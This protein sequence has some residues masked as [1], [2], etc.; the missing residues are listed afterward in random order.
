MHPQTHALLSWTVAEA[1]GLEHRRDRIIVLSAGLAPDLDGLTILGG[2]AL[3][4]DWHRTLLHHG[5]GALVMS[6][7]ALACARQRLRVGLLALVAVHLHFLCDMVG[8]AGPDGS[9][10]RVPY[11]VP[12]AM[13]HEH[14]GW[15]APWQWGLASWQNVAITIA[16]L[17]VCVQ[18]ARRRG[19]TLLEAVSLRADAAVVE[20]I[21][22]RLPP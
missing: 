4:N 18:L 5:L 6:L 21:R 13:P 19:R 15:A 8:S 16:A 3:Y 17:A 1:G 22:R 11:L 9:V 14:P 10:W 12:F 20:A 2:Q 7:V